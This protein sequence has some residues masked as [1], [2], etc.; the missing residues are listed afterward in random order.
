MGIDQ[1][2]QSYGKA[3]I[4]RAT[5]VLHLKV[6]KVFGLKSDSL[7]DVVE[8]FGCQSSIVG[9]FDARHTNFSR[10]KDQRSSSWLSQ[11][12]D[13]STKS[14][15]GNGK[16]LEPHAKSLKRKQDKR[17]NGLGSNVPTWIKLCITTFQCNLFQIQTNSQICRSSDILNTN[18]ER[19]TRK[20][21]GSFNDGSSGAWPV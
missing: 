7:D 1:S 15:G 8:F 12:H 6:H 10:G 17:N 9:G 21:I 16:K 11:S 18:Q 20:T 5:N 2:L 13:D 3:N 19:P 4:R 14:L